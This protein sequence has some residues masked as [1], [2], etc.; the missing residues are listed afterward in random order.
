MESVIQRAHTRTWFH[1]TLLKAGTP[2]TNVVNLATALHR[3]A[4]AMELDQTPG[5]TSKIF[6]SIDPWPFNTSLWEQ[7]E[8]IY[9]AME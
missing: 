5:W 8:Q 3:E 1:G 4:L 6:R 9:L 7:W 2:H